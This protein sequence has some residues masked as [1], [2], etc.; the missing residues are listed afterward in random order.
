MYK[1]VRY[2]DILQLIRDAREQ[3]IG[4]RLY[5]FADLNLVSVGLSRDE[6]I[7]LITAYVGQLGQD[8]LNFKQY[9][10]NRCSQ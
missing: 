2:V 8:T 6:Y 9:V 4:A 10:F 7:T 5:F 3:L 1:S